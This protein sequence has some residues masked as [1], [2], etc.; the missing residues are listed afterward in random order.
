V[1]GQ[2]QAP[3]SKETDELA[4]DSQKAENNRYRRQ[5]LESVKHHLKPN[6]QRSGGP[7]QFKI[8]RTSSGADLSHIKWS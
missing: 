8:A 6:R 2:W 1:A 4:V 5:T 3:N 7:R